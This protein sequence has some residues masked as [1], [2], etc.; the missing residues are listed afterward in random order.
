MTRQNVRLVT[1][2]WG[3]RYVD[4][5]LDY[6]LSAALAPGNLP[7]LAAVFNCTT[8]IVTEEKLF[9]YVQKHPTTRKLEQVC[10]VELIPLDDLVSDPWQ[11]GMTVAYALFRGFSGLGPAMTDTYLLFLNADFVMA[12]GCYLKLIDRIRRGEPVHLA[13][14]YCTVEEDVKPH[15]RKRRNQNG[16][17]LAIPPRDMAALILRHPHN[18]IRAKTVNQSIFEFEHADQ[19][20]WKFDAHTLFGYQMPIA[21]VGMRPEREL[22]DLNSFWDWGIVY[23]F[24]PSKQLAVIGDSDDFLMME[25]R[26]KSRSMESISFG[27]SSP[28]KIARRLKGHMTQY[29]LDNAQFELTL[30]SRDASS[31]LTDARRRLRAYVNG[32]LGHL[33]SIPSYRRKHPQWVYHLRHFRGRLERKLIRPRIGRIKSEI[34]RAQDDLEQERDLIDEYLSDD[35]REQALQLLEAESENTLRVLRQDLARLESE[36]ERQSWVRSVAQ[37]HRRLASAPYAYR[38]SRRW[39][40]KLIRQAA[41]DRPL[42]I[43][44][45]CP[46]DSLLLGMLDGVGGLHMH[47]TF[48]SIMEG[49][50]R[51]LPQST[52][53]FDVGLIELTEM[54]ASKAKELLGAVAGQ[55]SAPEI[56]LVHW[57]DQGTVPLRAV[58]NRIV[59]FTLDRTS[60]AEAYY[61]G[62]WAS[63]AAARA[64][65]QAR[66]TPAWRRFG[67]LAWLAALTVLAE[68]RERTRRN[69]VT[70]IPKYCSSAAFRI[71]IRSEESAALVKVP[72]V[73]T[74]EKSVFS[75]EGKA[76]AR[77]D[78]SVGITRLANKRAGSARR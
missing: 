60:Q 51:M 50:L 73:S 7:A 15:L 75:S 55:L 1:F 2:A 4:N 61:A 54:E 41:G 27:R 34:E 56:I 71:E 35:R 74:L 52:R 8:V 23:E 45:V 25:L 29:Q 20:Y 28:K 62:S 65:H 16:G 64:L 6:A 17:I 70:T 59:E 78:K 58:H 3:R 48:E 10:S 43:L 44:A 39:L 9:D 37:F 32:V 63:A 53:N 22:T 72:F 13:P 26:S 31:D 21:L 46:A 40:R 11:Y 77:Q 66:N 14:S 30:H 47:L 68:L 69:R 24:C 42:R 18:T 57:H 38:G 33:P 5:L 67:P 76:A 36:L 19:F 12:D 49:A